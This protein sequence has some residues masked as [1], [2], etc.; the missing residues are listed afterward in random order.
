MLLYR[1]SIFRLLTE[2]HRTPTELKV[3][4]RYTQQVICS[5]TIIITPIAL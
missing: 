2:A 4:H 3:R 1:A 5:I